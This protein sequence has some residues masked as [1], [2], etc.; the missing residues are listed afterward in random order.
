MDGDLQ[1]SISIGA[2]KQLAWTFNPWRANWRKPALAL[3]IV[4]LVATLAGWSF[5]YP[6]WW[7]QALG[8]GTISLT[9]LLGATATL[10]LP[11][12]YLLDSRGVSVYFLGVP[13]FRQWSHYRNYYMHD[14]GVHLTTMPKPSALDPFRGHYV[15]FSRDPS[16]QSNRALVAA[17]IEEHMRAWKGKPQEG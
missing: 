4:L 10:F 12:R 1:P 8:W 9:F 15:Q 14:T 16:G 13:S 6:D 3:T 2:T 5:T 11:V 17:F 7:P